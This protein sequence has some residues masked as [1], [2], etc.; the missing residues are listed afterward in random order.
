VYIAQ[1]LFH[2]TRT[3]SVIFIWIK[4]KYIPLD[5]DICLQKKKGLMI[6]ATTLDL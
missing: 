6:N 4:K 3:D 2:V 5:V 1:G